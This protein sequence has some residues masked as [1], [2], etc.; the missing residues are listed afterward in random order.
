VKATSGRVGRVFVLRLEDGDEVPRSIEEFAARERVG[1]AQVVLLGGVGS[2]SVIVGP[3]D[4]QDRPIEPLRLPLDG[5]HEVVGLGL[6]APDE[7]GLPALHVHAALGRSGHTVTGCLREGVRAWQVC[8]A[9]VME[10]EGALAAR[11]R[12]PSLGFSVLEPGRAGPPAGG[13]RETGAQ[14]EARRP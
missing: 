4:A 5:V 10:V 6:I 8:E 7:R 14:G 3:E 9:V 13:D 2:G 12:D 11:L 1:L